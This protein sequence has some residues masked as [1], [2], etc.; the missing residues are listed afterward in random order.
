MAMDGKPLAYDDA[1]L[2]R[3]FRETRAIAVVGASP[4]PDRPSHGVLRFL[5]ARGYRVFPV[6]PTCAGQQ[7]DG[8]RVW[9]SL[10]EVP[11]KIDMVDVFRNSAEAGP[12]VDEAVAVGARVVWMQL[13]V[14]DDRAAARGE[15]AGLTV[16]MDRCPAIELPRLERAGA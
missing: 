13:G 10:A 5:K 15:A 14:R 6:N 11:E 3:I 1:T 7:I 8:E 9:A 16:V 2:R 12:V 4:R